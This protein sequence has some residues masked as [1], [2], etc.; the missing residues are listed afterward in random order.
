[1]NL[2][3]N[4]VNQG[5]FV[6]SSNSL[7]T[8]TRSLGL[9]L[10]VFLAG[11]NAQDDHK[12]K[13]LISP[14]EIYDQFVELKIDDAPKFDEYERAILDKRWNANR[15]KNA[16]AAVDTKELLE[17]IIFASGTASTSKRIELRRVYQELLERNKSLQS[18]NARKRA[19]T[20]LIELHKTAMKG[21]YDLDCSTLE[22]LF[23]DGK[24]NC[25]SS[26]A[27]YYLLGTDL[28]LKLQPISIPGTE[29]Q[30]GH[31]TLD[32]IDDNKRVQIEP[33]NAEGYDWEVK[34]AQPGVISLNFGPPRSSGHDVDAWELPCMIYSNRAIKLKLEKLPPS[35]ELL[36]SYVAALC[37]G[38]KAP[39][40]N[41][42]LAAL[43]IN[44]GPYLN[45]SKRPDDA[46]RI[47]E[48][49]HQIAPHDK[50]I[51]N[52]RRIMWVKKI[53]ELLAEKRD[54]EVVQTVIQAA[55]AFPSDSEFKKVSRWFESDANKVF[56][57]GSLDDGLAVI[58]RALKVVPSAEHD[59]LINIRTTLVR[60]QSQ[61]ELK[62]ND[63][64]ASLNTLL[65]FDPQPSDSEMAAAVFLHVQ[66]A[67]R[68]TYE[69]GGDEL[70]LYHIAILNQKLPQFEKMQLQFHQ[71][72]TLS[73]QKLVDNNA[74]DEAFALAKTWQPAFKDETAEQKL[75]AYIYIQWGVHLEKQNSFDLAYEKLIEGMKDCPKNE[76]LAAYAENCV[77]R[78]GGE[79]IER[80]K[81]DEA[82]SIYQLGLKTF[83]KSNILSQNL[84]YCKQ[85]KNR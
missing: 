41:Q 67:L 42:N 74:F 37:L 27:L 7:S 64:D 29:Y 77:A 83:P 48:F 56:E 14:L 50:S 6:Q 65:R 20:L 82:I 9:V 81:W 1:M 72:A 53:L 75:R 5:R 15:D 58:S 31:A 22:E 55:K 85:E 57:S 25:V 84:D 44:W 80:K 35:G 12:Y 2:H 24:Y 51:E 40:P 21:G 38:P 10:F 66:E 13:F 43:L 47:M 68:I 18:L 26:T 30:A 63:V 61:R 60:L 78:W 59:Q 69:K 28:G 62:R 3:E 39:T 54:D 33:T 45:E 4:A 36:R 32:L 11:A 79:T 52:N 71:F 8:I 16:T 49:A 19:E 76:D 70:T 34:L 17:A 46:I 23:S 73:I